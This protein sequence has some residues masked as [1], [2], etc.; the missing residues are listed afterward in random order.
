MRYSLQSNQTFNEISQDISESAQN[1]VLYQLWLELKLRIASSL[2]IEIPVIR[3]MPN[4]AALV[5]DQLMSHT[6]EMILTT[7]SNF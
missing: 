6:L 2:G 5:K 1:A 4:I 7:N 3:C